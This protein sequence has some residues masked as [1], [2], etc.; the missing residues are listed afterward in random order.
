MHEINDASSDDSAELPGY[1]SIIF[2]FIAGIRNVKK[3]YVAYMV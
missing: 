1:N 2:E 3:N